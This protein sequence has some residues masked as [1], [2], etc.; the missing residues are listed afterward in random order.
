MLLEEHDI[1]EMLHSDTKTSDAGCSRVSHN[2]YFDCPARMEDGRAFT[3]YASL[4]CDLRFGKYDSYGH[5]QFLIT[6]ADAI[7]NMERDKAY[8]ALACSPCDKDVLLG[9]RDRDICNAKTCARQTMDVNGLGLG[10]WYNDEMTESVSSSYSLTPPRS[11][12]CAGEDSYYP[13][14]TIDNVNR[15]TTSGALPLS[16]GDRV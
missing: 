14:F 11:N 15:L 3:D 9:E 12:V 8:S 6:N 10:R 4:R 7:M 1:L 13:P 2:R 16:G 5:R